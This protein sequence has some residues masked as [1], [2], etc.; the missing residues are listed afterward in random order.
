MTELATAGWQLSENM[1][2]AV[3]FMQKEVGAEV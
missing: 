3:V 1:T 2:G